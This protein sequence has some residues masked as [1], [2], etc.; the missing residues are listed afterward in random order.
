MT[1]STPWT[2]LGTGREPCPATGTTNAE[3]DRHIAATGH[4][5]S[6]RWVP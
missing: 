5:I 2:C 1:P 3:A 6:L 4:G